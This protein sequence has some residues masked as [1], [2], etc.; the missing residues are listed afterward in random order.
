MSRYFPGMAAGGRHDSLPNHDRF[1]LHEHLRMRL[2]GAM[3]LACLSL[4]VNSGLLV[5]Q[6][7]TS[8]LERGDRVRLMTQAQRGMAAP[9]WEYLGFHEVHG[10][11]LVMEG[12]GAVR[13]LPLT[14]IRR[15]KVARGKRSHTALGAVLGTGAG[16][17]IG[18]LLS[19]YDSVAD[20]EELII[21]VVGGGVLGALIGSQVRSDRWVDVSLTGT[22]IGLAV[23]AP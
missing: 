21:A 10:D 1:L 5:A 22:S 14:S 17:G 16:A 3:L 7:T 9:E 23:P 8:D 15:L 11:S 12:D 13:H 19:G 6:V 2:H 18:A 4:L 20:R